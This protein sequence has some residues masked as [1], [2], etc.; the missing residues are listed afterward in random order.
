VGEL[1]AQFSVGDRELPGSILRLSEEAR[2]CR[3]EL[4]AVE[5]RLLDVEAAELY[6]SAERIGD[7]RLVALA[8]DG[9]G[10]GAEKHLALCLIARPRCVALV[11]AVQAGSV[12]FTFA[13]SDDLTLDVRPLLRDACRIVGGGG[14]GQPNLA[15]GGGTQTKEAKAAL[16]AAAEAARSQLQT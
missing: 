13:R 5:D 8:F 14:G 15:Q 3:R 11:G 12:Q 1:A 9:R 10:P 16:E 2:A 4:K 7:V 6:A